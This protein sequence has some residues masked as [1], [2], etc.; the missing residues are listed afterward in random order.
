MTSKCLYLF[1]RQKKGSKRLALNAIH[2]VSVVI[3][4]YIIMEIKTIK[5]QLFG[6]TKK[7]TRT[8]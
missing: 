6:T 5:K 8:P 4:W 7:V 2:S 3:V 1:L